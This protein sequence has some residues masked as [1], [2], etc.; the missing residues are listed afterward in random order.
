[1]NER[2]SIRS[3][4]NE[5]LMILKGPL[6]DKAIEKYKKLGYYSKEMRDARRE[7]QARK[8]AKR[9]KREGNFLVA[10]DGRLIFSPK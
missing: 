10:N 2:V 5:G 6:T 8:A 1:M 9:M 3:G 7:L 4:W